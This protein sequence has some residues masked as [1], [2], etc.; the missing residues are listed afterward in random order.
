M[1]YVDDAW[2]TGEHGQ[3]LQPT[4]RQS[5]HR[6][7][8]KL[9]AATQAAIEDINRRYPGDLNDELPNEL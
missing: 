6:P 9:P 1:R 8:G 3:Q 7:P 2:F 5:Q 4:A